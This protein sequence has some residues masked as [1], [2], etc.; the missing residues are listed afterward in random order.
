MYQISTQM[1]GD[2]RDTITPPM[3]NSNIGI[4]TSASMAEQRRLLDTE[5]KEPTLVIIDGTQVGYTIDDEVVEKYTKENPGDPVFV[6]RGETSGGIR[7]QWAL[8][9]Y[10]M[11]RTPPP[12]LEI[13]GSGLRIAIYA[14]QTK[15]E[16]P[17]I[18]QSSDRVAGLPSFSPQ[19]WVITWT[20]SYSSTEP[21][22]KDMDSARSYTWQCL[23]MDK[24]GQNKQMREFVG[25][26]IEGQVPEAMVHILKT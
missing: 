3:S 20:P 5:F 10:R 16:D 17:E 15:L 11:N 18:E 8:A 13:L 14:T 25:N 21:T 4:E 24:D 9:R 1:A 12:G 26:W 23:V 6:M 22:L 7:V 19:K 2:D